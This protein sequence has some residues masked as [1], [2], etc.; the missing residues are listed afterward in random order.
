MKK[1]IYPLL[2]ISIF[3]SVCRKQPVN[4]PK[5]KYGNIAI[6]IKFQEQAEA[7]SFEYKITPDTM[8]T[9]SLSKKTAAVDRIE[10]QLYRGEYF[11][12]SKDMK[13]E[14]N[15]GKVSFEVDP[16]E[17]YKIKGRAYEEGKI[18]Y[19][20][21]SD[22]F[23]IK[24]GDTK[25]I[26]LEMEW[27]LHHFTIDMYDGV[28]ETGKP[29]DLT[30]KAYDAIGNLMTGF[31]KTVNIQDFS[32]S[33]STSTII[34][35]SG[36]WSGSLTISQ[37]YTNNKIEVSH[38]SVY[39]YTEYFDVKRGLYNFE[40]SN[41]SS[42]QIVDEEFIITIYAKDS[43]SNTV[44]HFNET[45]DLSDETRT[46]TPSSVTLSSGVWTGNVKISQSYTNNWIK[47]SYGSYEKYSNYFDVNQSGGQTGTVTDIDGNDKDRR[48]GMDG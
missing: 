30:I 31:N 29:F 32:R 10:I 17:E 46:I 14:L 40:I 47:V 3:I 11:V 24:A 6:Q 35:N 28:I 27:I 33:L 45:I 26:E 41:I 18:K 2:I 43:E 37:P 13:K 25:K 5:N 21:E 19:R 42:P 38:A 20:G 9:M 7:H 34:F 8:K 39:T 22:I 4:E 15:T 44:T 48:P 16:G 23:D 1:I 36:I 12:K